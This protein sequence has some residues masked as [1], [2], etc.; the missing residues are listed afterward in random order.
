[1]R[2]KSFLPSWRYT[3]AVSRIM[4]C[5]SVV[6]A[7][8]FFAALISSAPIASNSLA[9]DSYSRFQASAVSATSSLA[10]STV[11]DFSTLAIDDFLLLRSRILAQEQK[12]P[13]REESGQRP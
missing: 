7:S 1:M 6:S 10:I 2:L 3:S 4:F 13:S 12:G 8:H 5:T 9:A 11:G